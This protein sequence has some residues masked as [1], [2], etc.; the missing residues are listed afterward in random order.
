MPSIPNDSITETPPLTTVLKEPES[1]LVADNQADNI[2]LATN[3]DNS[4]TPRDLATSLTG[5]IS[6]EDGTNIHNDSII[7]ANQDLPASPTR[8]TVPI[9]KEHESLS[10]TDNNNDSSAASE[11]PHDFATNSASHT[12]TSFG[13]IQSS[14]HADINDS[15]TCCA[16]A[17]NSTSDTSTSFGVRG[18]DCTTKSNITP[19]SPLAN[20]VI[21][22]DVAATTTKSDTS[23]ASPLASAESF[24]ADVVMQDAASPSSETQNDENLPTWLGK[25]IVYLRGVSDAPAWQDL[26]LRFLEFE[27]FGPPHGVSSC[28]LLI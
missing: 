1:L 2:T 18:E 19:A 13:S 12:S 7:E 22:Q 11:T 20:D 25:M 28:R 27:K 17:A 21:M 3:F 26:V 6:G 14:S 10:V 23:P 24:D 15:E 4:E 5:S 8:T 16:L 9:P